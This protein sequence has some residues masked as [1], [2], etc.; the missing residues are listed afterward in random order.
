MKKKKYV[1]ST[2]RSRSTSGKTKGGKDK[3]KFRRSWNKS[4]E[5]ETFPASN[6]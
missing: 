1:K 3:K 4:K 5:Q 2:K 6:L